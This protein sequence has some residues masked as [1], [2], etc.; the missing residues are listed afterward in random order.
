MGRRSWSEYPVVAVAPEEGEAPD[1]GGRRWTEVK[2]SGWHALLVWLVG[3][4]HVIRCLD[5]RPPELVRVVGDVDGQRTS[6]W[7]EPT[8][9][10]RSYV[11]SEIHEYLADAGVASQPWGYRWFVELPDGVEDGDRVF[12]RFRRRLA[13][14]PPNL[15]PAQERD[16]MEEVARTL[17]GEADE[18]AEDPPGRQGTG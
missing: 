15:T 12:S 17:Y 5:L 13:R 3:P 7:E 9:G 1:P 14:Y 6:R 11:E 18:D 2:E 8:Y 4:A 16:V 10:D